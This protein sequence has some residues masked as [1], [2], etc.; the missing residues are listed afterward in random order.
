M[1]TPVTRAARVAPQEN[2]IIRSSESSFAPSHDFES[3]IT[4]QAP[5]IRERVNAVNAMLCN[6]PGM[7]RLFID[8]RCRRLI[9]DLECVVWK[10]DGHGNV[11]AQLDKSDPELTHVSDALGYLV[12]REFGL[13]V[14]VGEGI[15]GWVAERGV[16]LLIDDAAHD[17][18]SVHVPGTR[19]D[20]E[21]SMM[22]VPMRHE[23]QTIGV[24]GLAS[25]PSEVMS[26]RMTKKPLPFPAQRSAVEP[27]P[28]SRSGSRL[29]FTIA[30]RRF[31]FEFSSRVTELKPTAARILVLNSDTVKK[32]PKPRKVGGVG[33]STEDS[34][35]G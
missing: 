30:D 4:Y 24:I 14:A 23:R 25:G 12:E 26:C 34:T 10:A 33:R 27:E 31:A 28:V 29:I 6:S 2:R 9:R 17:V 21:E 8:P 32:T 1:A 35:L 20:V 15:T 11:G 3:A 19:D 22:V 16:P 18:R 13:R 5:S 7:R